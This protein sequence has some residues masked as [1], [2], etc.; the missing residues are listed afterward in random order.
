MAEIQN[1]AE[2]LLQTNK[3]EVISCNQGVSSQPCKQI[4]S[5]KK[6][7]QPE[8]DEYHRYKRYKP[9]LCNLCKK[10]FDTEKSFEQ[11]IETH[12]YKQLTHHCGICRLTF[13]DR[14]SFE[15]HRK[16]HAVECGICGVKCVNKKSL[17]GHEGKAHGM[18]K[19]WCK[20]H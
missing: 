10:R 3:T 13:C 5:K 17:K 9:F 12:W 6:S 18:H 1:S 16:I 14:G 11:H 2:Q 15:E 8:Y 4:P 20:R 7:I 19:R